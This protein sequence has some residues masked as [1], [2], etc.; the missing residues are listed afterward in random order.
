MPD[1]SAIE[2]GPDTGHELITV[3]ERPGE[4]WVVLTRTG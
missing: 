4:N 2:A 1:V 3:L